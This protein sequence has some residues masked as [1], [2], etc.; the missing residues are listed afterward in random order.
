MDEAITFGQEI[1]LKFPNSHLS[2]TTKI[3][4]KGDVFVLLPGENFGIDFLINQ[5]NKKRPKAVIADQKISQTLKKLP[6]CWQTFLWKDL[7]DYVGF[8][9]AGFYRNPTHEMDVTAVTGTD[10]KTTTVN[11][12][13]SIFAN[14]FED[15]AAIGTLGVIVYKKNNKKC[16]LKDYSFSDLTTPSAVVL[17]N[18]FNR[19]KKEK[20]R[21]VFLEASSVGIITNRL[22]GVRIKNA[23]FT[24]L[25][26]DHL[27]LHGSLEN[28]AFSKSQLFAHPSL[29]NIIAPQKKQSQDSVVDLVYNEIKKSGARKIFVGVKTLRNK[30]QGSIP[31]ILIVER[32]LSRSGT[33]VSVIKNNEESESFYVNMFGQ[34]NLEN[35]SLVAGL[36]SEDLMVSH[37]NRLL[38]N[39]RLP[40][41]RFELIEMKDLPLVCIDY[42]HTPESLKVTLQTLIRMKGK[43]HCKLICVFGCG[44]NRDTNKRPIMGRVASHYADR[45]YIT[46]D[47]P[48]DEPITKISEEIMSGIT[49]GKK[50]EWTQ[51]PDRKKAIEVAIMEASKT[52]I[53]LI[54][55]KGHEKTQL[56]NG[57]KL[58][59]CDKKVVTEFIRRS[60]E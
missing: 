38:G 29:N 5:I 28:L 23:I 7:K 56:I 17:Q 19:L 57:L 13:A 41:G 2:D 37:A 46:S 54:A 12:A 3:F 15:T 26:N 49:H 11:L 10:G 6:Y 58:K 35:L 52:D 36:L 14:A 4:N 50:Q 40:E 20:I 55:G 21:K 9:A 1:S 30:G 18:I 51:I 45:G 27:D 59:F 22:Q 53:V 25:G 34:H 48:R 42:A 47:N 33:C 16:L 39:S 60:G 8:I 44:G 31:D 24:N 43:I 32:T